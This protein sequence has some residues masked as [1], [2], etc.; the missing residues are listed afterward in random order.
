MYNTTGDVLC[1]GAKTGSG[2]AGFAWGSWLFSGG[3]ASDTYPWTGASAW[4]DAAPGAFR[5]TMFA[6][7]IGA[8]QF[9]T[10]DTVATSFDIIP[11]H[12]SGTNYFMSY[13]TNAGSNISNKYLDFPATFTS[14]GTNQVA[15]RGSMVDVAHAPTGTG[16]TQGTVEPS[17][18]SSTTTIIGHFWVPNGNT[19][20]TF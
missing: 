6:N 18:G 9:W 1:L 7:G 11:P 12:T 14:Y 13:V 16:I 19:V 10:D 2:Y 4:N 8:V 5:Y 17:S 20:P 3:E 15:I